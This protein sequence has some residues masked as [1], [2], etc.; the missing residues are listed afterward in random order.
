MRGISIRDKL[1][2]L[3]GQWPVAVVALGVLLTV[4][5]IGVLIWTFLFFWAG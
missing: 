2:R 5:W 3:A 4:I 1:K